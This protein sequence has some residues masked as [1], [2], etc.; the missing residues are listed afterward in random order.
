LFKIASSISN[1]LLP[2]SPCFPKSELN[3]TI[4]TSLIFSNSSLKYINFKDWALNNG[5]S[6]NL[7]IDRINVKGNYEPSNC[8]FI[9]NKENAGKDKI[10]ISKEAYL[11]IKDLISKGNGVEDSYKS[12]G[13]S[14]SAYYR[15]KERYENNR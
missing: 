5:Y 14:R 11:K 3:L 8:C 1:S 13:F 12:L 9:S 6:D 15:A 4:S 7:T 10:K 2:V